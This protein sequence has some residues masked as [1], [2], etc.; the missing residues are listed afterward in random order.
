MRKLSILLTNIMVI[1]IVCWVTPLFARHDVLI[2]KFKTTKDKMDVVDKEKVKD[3]K[4][5]DKGAGT[6]SPIYE[7]RGMTTA[8]WDDRVTEVDKIVKK[9]G[10]KIVKH[11]CYHDETPI[12][13]AHPEIKPR[14]CEEVI[15]YEQ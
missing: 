7:E 5:V 1:T 8:E 15:I 14:P 4:A 11:T 3:K 13:P 6:D 10:G 9:Y 2:Y 12:D